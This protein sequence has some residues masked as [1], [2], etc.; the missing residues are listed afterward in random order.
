MVAVEILLPEA[1]N[2]AL[3][4]VDECGATVVSFANVAKRVTR[5]EELS[6]L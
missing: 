2:E 3:N 4:F 1:A 5:R 6:A